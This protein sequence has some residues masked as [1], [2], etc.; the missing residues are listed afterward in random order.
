MIK[1]SEF[2]IKLNPNGLLLFK[3]LFGQYNTSIP[4]TSVLYIFIS[5]SSTS[6]PFIQF[7]SHPLSETSRSLSYFL[8]QDELF[9]DEIQTSSSSLLIKIQDPSLFAKF[10]RSVTDKVSF[11]HMTHISKDIMLLYSEGSEIRTRT[12]EAS[13]EDQ[14]V[15]KNVVPWKALF[16]AYITTKEFLKVGEFASR[17]EG[18]V[19]IEISLKDKELNISLEVKLPMAMKIIIKEIK[20][21]ELFIDCPDSLNLRYILD[22]QR[23]KTLVIAS[24]I[25]EI[26]ELGITRDHRIFLKYQKKNENNENMYEMGFMIP[27]MDDMDIEGKDRIEEEEEEKIQIKEEEP[28]KKKEEVD[29]DGEGDFEEEVEGSGKRSN[30]Y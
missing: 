28:E 9:L 7:L 26:A 16:T 3:K 18:D 8:L 4:S 23:A 15:L 6:P 21:D 17:S 20:I 11:F 12:I 25:E 2:Q 1:Q 14:S 24:N 5:T 22:K 27:F 10:I 13:K 29:D 19:T 30:I